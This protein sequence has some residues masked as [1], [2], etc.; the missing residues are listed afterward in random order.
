MRAAVQEVWTSTRLYHTHLAFCVRMH[1]KDSRR[2]SFDIFKRQGNLLRCEGTMHNLCFISHKMPFIS[3][4]FLFLHIRCFMNSAVK[5]THQPGRLKVKAFVN[6]YFMENQPPK[7]QK[8]LE[9]F[10]KNLNCKN[11]PPPLLKRYDFFVVVCMVIWQV[12]K[13]CGPSY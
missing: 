12:A 13:T 11:L 9:T 8:F 2:N 10:I 3:Y 5:C 4:L 6:C 1:K 7:C